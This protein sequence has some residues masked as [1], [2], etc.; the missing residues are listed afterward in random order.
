AAR[1]TYTEV[2]AVL[3]GQPSQ[4]PAPIRE[5]LDALYGLFRVQVAARRERGA[6]E[7]DTTETSIVCDPA[8]RILR[9]EPTHRND[10]HRLIEECM[11][12]AN[13]CA[14]DFTQRGK[15]PA[16]Y[17]VHE[18]PTPDR[19]AT[20][21]EFLRGVGLS[22]GT[23]NEDPTPADYAALAQ[24]IQGR[25]DADLLQTMLLRSMQQA[26][27]TPENVG[28]FG[29]AYEAYA[30]FTSPIRRYPDLLTHRVIKAL[31]RGERYRLS[32]KGRGKVADEAEIDAW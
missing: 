22:L 18:G 14:A 30:H 27:Y 6:L 24:K 31:V 11:L 23:T 12:V 19:L 17:R 1:L 5:R 28:H 4:V 2:W 25:P 20:L 21:R 29:L 9:I 8:G 16:L 15:H 3:S 32:G 10:A 26:I 7:F 13:T